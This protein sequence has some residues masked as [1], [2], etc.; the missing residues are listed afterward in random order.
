MSLLTH[1]FQHINMKKKLIFFFIFSALLLSF[2]FDAF[3]KKKEQVITPEKEYGFEL[4]APAASMVLEYNLNLWPVRDEFIF[5]EGKQHPTVRIIREIKPNGIEDDTLS[6]DENGKILRVGKLRN[7]ELPE[8]ERV[9]TYDE[10][11]SYFLKCYPPVGKRYNT[12]DEIRLTDFDKHGNWRKA[13]FKGDKKKPILTR[14]ITYTLSPEQEAILAR[15]KVDLANSLKRQKENK[16]F[17]WLFGLVTAGAN[18]LLCLLGACLKSVWGGKLRWL[19]WLFCGLPIAT[20]AY[21]YPLKFLENASQDWNIAYQFLALA[22]YM[23]LMRA[24]IKSMSYDRRLSNGFINGINVVWSIWAFFLICPMF[25]SSL[26]PNLAGRI[27]HWI[28]AV[29]LFIINYGYI[30]SRCPVCRNPHGLVF[31][32]RSFEGTRT[33]TT[34]SHSDKIKNPKVVGLSTTDKFINAT[35]QHDTTRTTTTTSETYE[36]YKDHYVCI[37][38]GYVKNSRVMKGALI[39]R[40]TSTSTRKFKND[41]NVSGWL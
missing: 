30:S 37:E 17:L 13:Y 19:I 3:S 27:L 39:G 20:I 24:A 23:L 10:E 34:S 15:N 1:P 18:A 11:H 7:S 29:M 14:T 26:L 40:N 35:V 12:V 4:S 25:M 22:V 36:L 41:T 32:N 6:Y 5:E 16:D 2:P 28:L 21:L 38:C 33:E 8:R 9:E 31:Y